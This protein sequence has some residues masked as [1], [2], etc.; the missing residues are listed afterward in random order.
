MS[1]LTLELLNNHVDTKMSNSALDLSNALLWH[2]SF[3]V[4]TLIFFTHPGMQFR[5]RGKIE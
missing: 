4:I 3:I 5:G 1:M 2:M